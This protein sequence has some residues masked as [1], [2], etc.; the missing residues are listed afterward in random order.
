[1]LRQNRQKHTLSSYETLASGRKANH[2]HAD[3]GVIGLH[4]KTV[5]LPVEVA[6]TVAPGTESRAKNTRRDNTLRVKKEKKEK[7]RE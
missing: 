5:S 2:D 3:L 6:V 4:S 1:L 7:K